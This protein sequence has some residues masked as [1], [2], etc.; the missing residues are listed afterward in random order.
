MDAI[1]HEKFTKIFG[2]DSSERFPFRDKARS[3]RLYALVKHGFSLGF[4]SGANWE[5][6]IQEK[7]ER[8]RESLDDIEALVTGG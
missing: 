2:K 5:A 4:I 7:E 8:D 1:I 6:G 3:E